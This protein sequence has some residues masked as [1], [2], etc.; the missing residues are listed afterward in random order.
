VVAKLGRRTAAPLESAKLKD[1][2][3]LW[4]GFQFHIE[5][6]SQQVAPA[7]HSAG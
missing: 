7:G 2:A 6:T 4:Q 1:G 5:R 3:C